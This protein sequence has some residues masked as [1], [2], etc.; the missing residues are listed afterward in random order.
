S[1]S[2]ALASKATGFPIAKIAALLSIGYRLSEITNDITKSTPCCYEPALDY[3]VTKI[4]RFAFEK[5]PGS[6]DSLSTQMKSVGEVMGIGR[7]FQESFLKAL[8][9]L[10]TSSKAEGFKEVVFEEQK[11][12]YPNSNRI[13]HIAQALGEGKSIDYI[14]EL[15]QI[16]Y[17]FLER[18]KDIIDYEKILSEVQLDRKTLLEAKRKGFSDAQIAKIKNVS[19]LSIRKLRDEHSVLPCFFQ[20]DT[21]AAEFQSETPYY[22]STYWSEPKE[23]QVKD[24]TIVIVGSGPNRIGQGI[25][26]D[27][28][29]V[30]GVQAIQREGL[31]VAM[32]NSNPET[33]STDYDTSNELYFE[34]LAFEYV[35]EVMRSI[36][37]KGFIPQ[38]GGQTSIGLA[39]RLVESG[40]EL[41]GS[42]LDTIDL[43]EDRG[44]FSK[45]CKEVDLKIPKSKMIFAVEEA[46][47]FV[48][49]INYPVLCR[50][51]YVIGGRRMEVL[52]S[53]EDLDDYFEKYGEFISEENPFM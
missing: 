18:F 22:Y 6:E 32:I 24:D 25:E 23:V 37:P 19:E 38:W 11:I 15:S 4:P 20:V 42:S 28:G 40:F 48:K 35:Y 9:S 30:R 45:L 16:D 39:H 29:C 43:A 8:H 12:A 1:R 26:F 46:K 51:S 21:C 41:L 31:K 34:P 52:E 3:V 2:S 27:Y 7:T 33:V 17:W 5:F 44:K 49:E 10:E 53:D 36:S 50:P 47:A 14:Y 13:H